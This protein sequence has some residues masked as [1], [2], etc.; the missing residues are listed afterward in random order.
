MT[1]TYSIFFIILSGSQ[2]NSLVFGQSILQAA[3]PEGTALDTRLQKLF[4]IL[5]IAAICQLQAFS[6]INYV[7]FSNLFAV[8]KISFLSII[9]IL[10]WCALG[11]KRTK[12]AAAG[13]DPY[14]ITNLKEIFSGTTHGLYPISIAMLDIS[15]I[16]SGYENANF[17]LEEV[18]RPRRDETRVFRYAARGTI[19]LVWFFYISVNISLVCECPNLCQAI[20]DEDP[21][22]CLLDR[23]VNKLFG[24]LGLVLREGQPTTESVFQLQLKP[25]T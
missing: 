10:G 2:A 22:R 19:I 6:R 7:R 20:I 15:R 11:D 14:G 13:D 16:Y 18:R 8:Y 1:Y 3:T 21:V 17:V 23:G 9:M 24:R 25:S 12:V 4:A 5:L